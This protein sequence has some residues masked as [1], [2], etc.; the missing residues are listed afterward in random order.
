M[1][2]ALTQAP[3]SPLDGIPKFVNNGQISPDF[4]AVNTMQHTYQPSNNKPAPG[5]DPRFADSN[6]PNTLPPQHDITIGD[7][8]KPQGR[9]LG[10]VC[11]RLAGCARRRPR[12][13][14]IISGMA[15]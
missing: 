8:L 3:N 5:G 6:A 1:P 9:E 4:Y 11:R 12:P 15:V 14:L 10:L 7:L 2:T 13:A